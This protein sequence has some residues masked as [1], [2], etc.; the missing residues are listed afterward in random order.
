MF[1]GRQ[2][3]GN[4]SS[5]TGNLTSPR[6]GWVPEPEE[7]R[8]GST[9]DVAVPPFFSF[10]SFIFLEYGRKISYPRCYS[11]DERSRFGFENEAESSK[12]IYM[13]PGKRCLIIEQGCRHDRGQGERG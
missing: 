2:R 13:V 3:T 4:L 11:G 5:T 9:K 7:E 10:P 12:A 6:C 1:E 8:A